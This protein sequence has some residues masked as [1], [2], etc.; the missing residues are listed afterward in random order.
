[1]WPNEILVDA[2]LY[3]WN[4]RIDLN[5]QVYLGYTSWGGVEAYKMALLIESLLLMLA[6]APVSPLCARQIHKAIHSG[7]LSARTEELHRQMHMFLTVQIA[8]PTLLMHLPLCIMFFL[9]FTG[10]PSPLIISYLI[11]IAMSLN[12]LLASVTTIM[13]VKDYRKTL[14]TSLH[15]TKMQATV[16]QATV[17]HKTT[18]AL[19]V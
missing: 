2:V 10:L 15:L 17:A 14:L 6:L 7:P 5:S 12:P 3:E 11:G 8:C 9:F 19:T 18:F 4:G 1:M 13:Y 16:A